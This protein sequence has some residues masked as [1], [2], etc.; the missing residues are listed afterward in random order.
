ML[1]QHLPFPIHTP[2]VTDTNWNC[3][4][5]VRKPVLQRWNQR[6]W[7]RLPRTRLLLSEEETIIIWSG[8]KAEGEP[9]TTMLRGPLLSTWWFWFLWK[10]KGFTI[11]IS[12]PPPFLNTQKQ[13]PSQPRTE[14]DSDTPVF[15]KALLVVLST[16]LSKVPLI[17]TSLGNFIVTPLS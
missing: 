7:L 2:P 1:T 5:W 16:S 9:N 8:E 3:A 6:L 17:L 15:Y 13:E 14:T 12:P 10:D 4:S 11:S